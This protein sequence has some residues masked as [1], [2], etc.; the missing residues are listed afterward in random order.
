M[1]TKHS[2][3]QWPPAFLAEEE[4]KTPRIVFFEDVGTLSLL[5]GVPGVENRF[6]RR[7]LRHREWG[8]LNT[9]NEPEADASCPYG[10]TIQ[11]G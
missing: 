1:E 3:H 2:F 7:I 11:G 4:T 6:Y 9:P 10:E 5:R 8:V